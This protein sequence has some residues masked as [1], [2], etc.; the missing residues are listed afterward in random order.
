MDIKNIVRISAVCWLL[1]HAAADTHGYAVRC[2]LAD[3]PPIS[4]TLS[5]GRFEYQA[6]LNYADS[7][8]PLSPR[9]PRRPHTEMRG[10]PARVHD[11]TSFVLGYV[12]YAW[13]SQSCRDMREGWHF[14][15]VGGK[16][17]GKPPMEL[18]ATSP[19]GDP[20]Y[21]PQNYPRLS[22]NKSMRGFQSRLDGSRQLPYTRLIHL[23]TNGSGTFVN[24]VLILGLAARRDPPGW[25][26]QRVIHAALILPVGPW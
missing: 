19:P 26:V 1:C 9:D 25:C 12:S 20:P 2:M 21:A 14:S 18:D 5:L 23:S 10:R 13:S 6:S 16:D 24:P 17:G 8:P 4:D 7:K 22:S 15:H 3:L 11:L